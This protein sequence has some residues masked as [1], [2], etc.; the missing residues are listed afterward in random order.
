LVGLL[1]G[2][3]VALLFVLTVVVGGMDSAH[4]RQAK[5]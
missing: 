2:S 5:P 1:I 3:R 4:R